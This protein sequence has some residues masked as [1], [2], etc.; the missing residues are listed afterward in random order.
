MVLV[1]SLDRMTSNVKIVNGFLLFFNS[2]TPL[3]LKMERI[4]K[5]AGACGKKMLRL[6]AFKLLFYQSDAFRF[7]IIVNTKH[8]IIN[9]KHDLLVKAVSN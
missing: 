9:N 3:I 7:I 1:G 4:R 8:F 2:D 5:R 6:F